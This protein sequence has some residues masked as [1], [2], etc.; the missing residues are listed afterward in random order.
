LRTQ[1]RRLPRIKGWA[2]KGT[3]PLS[4]LIPSARKAVTMNKKSARFALV[5]SALFVLFSFPALAE[6]PL[7][8]DLFNKCKAF[9]KFLHQGFI[10][11]NDYTEQESAD[12]SYCIGYILG[13]SDA[14]SGLPGGF[15]LPSDS[16][17]SSD[18]LVRLFLDWGKR[19]KS[20]LENYSSSKCLFKALLE[21]F[22]CPKPHLESR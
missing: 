12:A 14:G 10:H 18:Q 22:P 9:E 21:T 8:Q 15:C 4:S 19:N 5:L 3:L 16:P 7:G 6:V 20:S 1:D 13:Y 11:Q 2:T 17:L